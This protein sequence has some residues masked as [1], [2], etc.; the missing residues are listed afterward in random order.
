MHHRVGGVIG[1]ATGS[2]G[3]EIVDSDV[4]DVLL[5]GRLAVFCAENAGGT[6]DFVSKVE[7]ALF[8]EGEDGDGGDRLGDGRDAEEAGLLDLHEMLP[9]PHADGLVVDEL[10]VAGD[11][12]GTWRERR[13]AGGR[14]RQCVPS[15][16]AADRR[17]PVLWLR[18]GLEDGYGDGGSSSRCEKVFEER[19]ASEGA[20]WHKREMFLFKVARSLPGNANSTLSA[21]EVK[22]LDDCCRFSQT[23][24]SIGGRCEEVFL[25]GF[26]LC[27][28]VDGLSGERGVC[29]A[30]TRTTAA[31]QCC[32]EVDFVL[33]GSERNHLREVPGPSA[34]GVCDQ[35]SFQ[36]TESVGRCRRHDH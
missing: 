2:V 10:A 20:V 4:G 36:R 8:D 17:A 22:G 14:P 30:T 15:R 1:P 31:C 34:R 11:G 16:P 21:E 32:R 12:N 24:D 13:I 9:V 26:F 28:W 25:C 33:Q 19:A 18:E 5:V 3:Q 23:G 7:L 6:E 35:R 29:A 27:F